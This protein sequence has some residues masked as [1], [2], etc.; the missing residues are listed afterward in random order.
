MPP[1]LFYPLAPLFVDLALPQDLIQS[2]PILHDSGILLHLLGFEESPI[3]LLEH[4]LVVIRNS[5][6]NF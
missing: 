5:V 1:A 3:L 6:L 4:I 2:L